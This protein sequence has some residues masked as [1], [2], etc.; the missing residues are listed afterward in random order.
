[1]ID[2]CSDWRVSDA[3]LDISDKISVLTNAQREGVVR[4]RLRGFAASTAQTVTFLDAHVEVN[5]F[6][7]EP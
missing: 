3:V 7:L 2:D 4:S 1:M 6:W 5:T